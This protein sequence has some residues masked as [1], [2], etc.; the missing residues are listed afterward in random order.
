ML[1]QSPCETYHVTEKWD[2]FFKQQQSL[3]Y[4]KWSSMWAYTKL[5]DPIN[6]WWPSLEQN[7]AVIISEI[8]W[9]L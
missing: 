4:D 3:L 8:S 6:Y 7:F 5:W 9:C 2:I 1:L